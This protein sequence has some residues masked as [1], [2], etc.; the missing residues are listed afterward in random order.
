MEVLEAIRNRRS[1]R[2]F[3]EEPIPAEVIGKLKEALILA[4]SAR[5]LQPRKFF[6]I[7][8]SAVREQF[9]S[10]TSQD[11][12][13]DAPLIV[14]A[15]RDL[16]KVS[17]LADPHFYTVIDTTL[18]LQNMVLAATELGLGTCYVGAFERDKVAEILDLPEHLKP[19]LLIPVGFPA[20][21][22]KAKPRVAVTEVVTEI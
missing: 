15:C 8:D 13:G 20:E 4:P 14:V 9:H 17:D 10:V 19:L 12:V 16:S 22:P 18:S 21:E 6:F 1:V 2:K 3:K 5:N 11:F 7:T